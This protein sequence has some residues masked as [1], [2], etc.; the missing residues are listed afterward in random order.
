MMM[1]VVVARDYLVISEFQKVCCSIMRIKLLLKRR[2]LGR[3]KTSVLYNSYLF[4]KIPSLSHYYMK[5][6]YFYKKFWSTIISILRKEK[7]WHIVLCIA[8]S[9]IYEVS[10]G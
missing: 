3:I 5:G 4:A 7:I 6:I 10:F 8:S 1:K 9:A 2:D